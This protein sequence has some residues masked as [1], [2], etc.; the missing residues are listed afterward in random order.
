MARPMFDS[1]TAQAQ[2]DAEE[3]GLAGTLQ[4][5]MVLVGEIADKDDRH[6]DFATKIQL[7]AAMLR[8]T[9]KEK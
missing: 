3:Y 8:Q 6:G 5:V 2:F 1:Y 7:I 9:S 4:R